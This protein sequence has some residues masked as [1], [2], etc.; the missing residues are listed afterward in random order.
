MYNALFSHGLIEQIPRSTF[1]VSL[2]RAKRITTSG[3]TFELHRIHPL[4]FGG[5]DT[6]HDGGAGLATAEKALFDTIYLLSAQR[7]RVT[8]PEVELPESFDENVLWEWVER[9]PQP[10]PNHRDQGNEA[11]TGWDRC[12]SSLRVSAKAG[13]SR[14][15]P[16]LP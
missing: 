15:R 2:D 10:A 6:Q 13:A 16:W 8:L 3:G 12:R 1:A 11:A 7:G 9:S 4:L 14:Q 5:F